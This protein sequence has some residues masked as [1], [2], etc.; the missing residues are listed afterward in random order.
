MRRNNWVCIV[1]LVVV[2]AVTGCG[3]AEPAA[4]P[5]VSG[6][7]TA[8]AAAVV[9]ATG[10]V[11]PAW[12]AT[13]SLPAAGIAT[14]LLVEE[15]QTVEAGT[16]LLRL[17]DA[18]LQ[19]TRAEAQA[20]LEAAQARLALAETGARPEELAAAQAVLSSTQALAA[21]AAAQRDRV[22]AGT[23]A[24]ELTMARAELAQAEAQLR[25]AEAVHDAS[26]AGHGGPDEW[27]MRQLRDQAAA[28]VDAARAKV[29]LLALGATAHER[30]AAQS[31]V[32]AA[33]AQ[34][35]QAQAQLDL[36]EAGARAQE[37]A[38][39]RA[40]VARAEAAVSAA[41]TALADLEL[42]APF[43]GTVSA[44]Y[45]R[46]HEWVNPGQ[47][48][49]LLADLAHLR[50]E[51]TDLNEIDA[52]RVRVGAA[53][54][55][56]FDALTDVVVDGKVVRLAPKAAEGSGVNYTAIIEL[57]TVPAALRW[58]MTAFADIVVGE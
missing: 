22:L 53:V 55:V 34:V 10:K 4:Q 51:T 44:V 28:A 14:E 58:D 56:T 45:I 24:D 57:G 25:Y 7:P 36:L 30:Q 50:I 40:D 39:L 26:M 35:A 21:E 54:R 37:L 9:S 46:A 47:P 31:G 8:D 52:A 27:Q 41:D 6:T 49:L 48:V 19:A 17:Q 18:A 16:P 1:S 11:T 29:H 13:L 15:G 3:A 5:P 43:A 20:G 32:D 38:A 33:Q 2:L 12:W 23:R 42:R